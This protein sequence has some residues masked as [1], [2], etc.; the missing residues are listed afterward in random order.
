MMCVCMH[1]CMYVCM[2][3]CMSVCMYVYVHMY[4][5]YEFYIVITAITITHNRDK[6][7]HTLI[8]DRSITFPQLLCGAFPEITLPENTF[9]H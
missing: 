7:K 3:V 8:I 5:L 2:Y 9:P 6:Q 4:E 1:A